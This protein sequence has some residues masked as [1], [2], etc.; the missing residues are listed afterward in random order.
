MSTNELKAKL[1]AQNTEELKV[2]TFK[3]RY[4][5]VTKVIDLIQRLSNPHTQ[6][7]MS[8]TSNRPQVNALVWHKAR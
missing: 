1:T 6:I 5:A 8:S 4:T 7:C 2:G 3:I